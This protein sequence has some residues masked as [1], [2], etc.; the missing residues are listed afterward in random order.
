MD[1]LFSAAIA[2]L[3]SGI[4]HHFGSVKLQ[5]SDPL[6]I[7]T[8]FLA[9]LKG[10]AT[11]RVSRVT[12]IVL[13][14]YLLDY[15]VSALFVQLSLAT[16]KFVQYSLV[17]AFLFTVFGYYR[18]RSSNRMLIISTMLIL[19]ILFVNVGWHLTHGEFV[20]W[21]Q[22]NEPKTIFIMLPLLL[23]LLFSR[24][25]HFW[26]PPLPLCAVCISAL[27]IL[28]S[29]ERKAYIY[30][31]IA[32]LIWTEPRKLWRYG[33]LSIAAIPLLWIAASAD[34][35]GYLHRQ[36]TSLQVLISDET[37]KNISDSQLIDA[38]RPTTLS[39]AERVFT[40]RRAAA[41]WKRRPLLGIG[42]DAFELEME[43]QSSIPEDFRLGIHGE[44]F[45]ALYENGL[46]GLEL[47]IA[48]WIVSFACIA[49]MWSPTNI[50]GGA[51]LNKIKFL[52]VLMFLIYSSFESEKELMVY[53]TCS[54]PFVLGILPTQTLAPRLR[55]AYERRLRAACAPRATPDFD[56]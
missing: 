56:V 19:A 42:T 30:A 39:N 52:S 41:M 45:R 1:L 38:N 53:V 21:K 55:G 4:H 5:L 48:V 31:P 13:L 8:I 9:A 17:F 11:P 37:T 7:L 24:F 33:I 54:L 27:I 46:V 51:A 20:G 23:I 49:M 40:N 2:S 18:T 34:S 14:A 26:R 43:Q 3:F 29:G 32:L 47:Y 22:L 15:L 44:F 28:L 10:F 6:A 25:P 36:L 50:A 16:T 35:S 12:L